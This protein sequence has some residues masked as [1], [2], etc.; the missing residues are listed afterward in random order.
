MSELEQQVERI[1]AKQNQILGGL[2]TNNNSETTDVLEQE[3][4]VAR[5]VANRLTYAIAGALGTPVDIVSA[6][7]NAGVGYTEPEGG[8]LFSSKFNRRMIKD[9]GVGLP[10]EGSKPENVYERGIEI[11]GHSVL[12]VMKWGQL[13]KPVL[14]Q[15]SKTKEMLLKAKEELKAKDREIASVFF[16]TMAGDEAEKRGFG[17]TGQAIAEL[18]GS[19]APNL[20]NIATTVSIGAQAVKGVAGMM[21]R[22]AAES[23][24]SKR[25]AN[26][27]SDVDT[28]KANLA[29]D[30][31]LE[32]SPVTQTDDLGLMA[33]QQAA[34]DD[35][36]KLLKRISDGFN[37]NIKT[38]KKLILQDGSPQYTI[39]YLTGIK[40][41]AVLN[42]KNK[43]DNLG[44]DVDPVTASIALRGAI[45]DAYTGAR[46][47]ETKIWGQ[48][49]EGAYTPQE[50]VVDT[51]RDIL[52][53]RNVADDPADI[54]SFL[55][56]LIGEQT[57]TGFVVG[58]M[59]TDTSL[60]VLKTLRSR[61]QQQRQVERALDVPNNKKLSLLSRINDTVLE[62]LA[63]VSPEYAAAVN[64]SREL[65]KSFT[66]GRVG[67]LMGFEKTGGRTVTPEGTFSYITSG[68]EI[69]QG[70]VLDRLYLRHQK[71]ELL[72][73]KTLKVYLTNQ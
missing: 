38:A 58:A 45:D 14:K 56:Q 42:A 70:K 44:L 4:S 19:F 57:K 29:E 20:S 43:I 73:L 65:N 15:S 68:G 25:I 49:D 34:L 37:D 63:E 40:Q 46:T 11:I 60:G 39:D 50:D 54:P 66:S 32:L 53:E 35:D 1:K 48:L 31:I 26:Q 6:M 59:K 51:F 13:A 5:G 12:P 52:Y 41:K 72:W 67:N 27:T 22:G 8:A 28:A 17:E 64:Y 61:I 47:L 55:Y 62:T 23:R 9:L 18:L 33:L 69:K 24:A 21:G 3:E 36:P 10:E 71:L 2:E 7:T 16:A 30:S